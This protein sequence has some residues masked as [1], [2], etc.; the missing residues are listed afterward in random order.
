MF[1]IDACPVWDQFLHFVGPNQ[2][3]KYLQWLSAEDTS[4]GKELNDL[5]LSC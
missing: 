3:P 1:S 2:G 4:S 5:F